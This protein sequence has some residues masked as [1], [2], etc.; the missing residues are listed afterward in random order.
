MKNLLLKLHD[1]SKTCSNRAQVFGEIYEMDKWYEELNCLEKD[2][3]KIV[4]AAYQKVGDDCFRKIR[5][6]YSALI[7][8][9]DEIRIYA[10]PFNLFPLYYTSK[11][12]EVYVSDSFFALASAREE[13]LIVNQ[14]GLLE[15]FSFSPCMSTHQSVYKNMY[16]LPAGHVLIYKNHQIKVEKWYEIPVYEIKDSYEESVLKVR[17]LVQA[18]IEAQK[19][20]VQASF[21]SGG[22]DSSV[23]VSQCAKD[24]FKTYSLDYE[25]NDKHFQS[26]LFQKSLDTPFIDEMCTMYHLNHQAYTITQKE[27][28]DTLEEALWA[29]EVPGMADIDASLYWFLG[30]VVKDDTIVF[31]GECA[32]E[33]FGGYPWFYRPEYDHSDSFPFLAYQKER[34]LLL[35]KNLQRY[36]FSS[37]IQDKYDACM[38]NIKNWKKEPF[39]QRFQKM[40]HLTFD[41]FMQTLV[42]RQATMSKAHN[43]TIRVPFADV[44]LMEYVY[45]LPAEYCMHDNQEKGI[46]RDA[47]KMDLPDSIHTRKKNPFPKTHHPLFAELIAQRLKEC[48]EKDSVL[49]ELFDQNALE[50]L[51]ETKGESYKF[52]W[53]GQLM[54]GPQLLA[55]LYTLHVWFS[56]DRIQLEL[57]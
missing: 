56:D 38:K 46:L 36:P 19:E 1:L 50:E 30:K 28:C 33:V 3:N 29:R 13:K 53:F 27:L 15:L 37:Y 39:N 5:G 32:D 2:A 25:E 14:K 11:D 22:L 18:S 57:S 21:L 43:I 7:Q 12:D 16:A 35:N 9:E 20:G 41:Y 44:A 47:F 48:L 23:I 54:S 6:A 8:V 51:I 10:P 40:R 17:E 49:L 45:N 42:I 52:P 4:Y 26:N 31:S 24:D 55:Y 34:I